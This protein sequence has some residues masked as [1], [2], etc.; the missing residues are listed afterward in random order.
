MCSSTVKSPW[1][2]EKI[3]QENHKV[4][5]D[6]LVS[7]GVSRLRLK[8]SLML[9]RSP[10]SRSPTGS[11]SLCHELSSDK[12]WKIC[13]SVQFL[14]CLSLPSEG[15]RILLSDPQ[16]LSSASHISFF[17]QCLLRREVKHSCLSWLVFSG[18]CESHLRY[19]WGTQGSRALLPLYY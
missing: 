1:L 13:L 17:Q 2:E 3:V 16:G 8:I 7:S 15:L 14:F 4:T 5:L 10:F 18:H 6:T 12:E 9:R 19:G 11:L